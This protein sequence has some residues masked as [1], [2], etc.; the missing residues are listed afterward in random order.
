MPK[1]HSFKKLYLCPECNRVYGYY[2]NYITEYYDT[3]PKYGQNKKICEICKRRK[4][5]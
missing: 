2:K 3:I 1:D 4:A 5:A